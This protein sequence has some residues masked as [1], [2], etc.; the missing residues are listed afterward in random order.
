[1]NKRAS[2]SPCNPKTPNDMLTPREEAHFRILKALEKNPSLTQR[3]LAEQLGLSLGKVN[4]QLNALIDKGAIKLSN[5]QRGR[6]KLNKLVYLLTP[7]G[8]RER[9][10]LTQRYLARKR[11]EYE[12]LKTEIESLEQ[13][14]VTSRRS[15]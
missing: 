5:F 7:K 14:V 15:S 8:L 4:Y 11:A 2:L 13:D 9:L 3:Q 10:Q 12:A 6:G 1:M